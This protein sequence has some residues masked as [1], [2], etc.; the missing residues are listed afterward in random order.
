MIIKSIVPLSYE[1]MYKISSNTCSSFYVRQEYLSNIEI[2]KIECGS[3][4]DELQT[5]EMLDAGLSCAVELKAVEYLARAEQCKF[6]LSNKLLAKKF[7]KKYI[8]QALSFLE[9][10]NYLNDKRFA[11]AWINTRR[12]N[13]FEGRI[14]LLAELQ[15]R[16]IS[17]EIANEAID[18][19]FSENDEE[20]ICKKAFEK[21]YK[22]GKRDEKLIAAMMNAGF[23]YKMV[24]EIMNSDL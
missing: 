12:I 4:F 22:H 6:G 8:E 11:T 24:K 18:E 3:E 15:H 5:D 16:G 19:Y 1:G 10:K 17:K 13:H 20:Y 9:S 7:D 14:K 23:P 2:D 21:F